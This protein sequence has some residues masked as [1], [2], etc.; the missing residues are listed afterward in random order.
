[1]M[2]RR[3]K[4][5]RIPPIITMTMCGCRTT[6]PTLVDSCWHKRRTWMRTMT[7]CW[8]TWW[9]SRQTR[10]DLPLR[11]NSP[12]TT[13]ERSH[14]EAPARQS[15][16]MIRLIAMKTNVQVTRFSWMLGL[17]DLSVTW[18]ELFWLADL[19]RCHAVIGWNWSRHFAPKCVIGTNCAYPNVPNTRCH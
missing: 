12:R 17:T 18:N 7:T 19:C 15:T 1:M 8:L 10:Q 14:L 13:H 4:R 11:D 3:T 9:S 6:R 2:R 16:Q 5:T